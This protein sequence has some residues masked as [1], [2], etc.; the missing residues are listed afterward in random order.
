MKKIFLIIVWLIVSAQ[1]TAQ[2]QN[3]IIDN[4]FPTIVNEQ[5]LGRA[6]MGGDTIFISSARTNPLKFQYTNGNADHPLVVIN[7]GGQVKIDRSST[8]SWGAIT[9]ENCKYIKISGSGHPNYKYGFQLAADVCGLAFSDLSS[10]C[11]AEFI[12][13]SHD[14]FYGIMAKK[15]YD[16]NP[17][18][19]YPL[20]ENLLIHDC[21]IE[22]VSEGM[23]LGE[24][25]SPGM[26]FKHVKIY[27]NIVR[28]TLR[29]TIQIANMVEDVEIY[30][31]TLLNAGLEN[32]AFQSNI[33]QIGDNSVANVYNNILI[34]A[35]ST[36]II[37]F[38]KGDCHFTNNYLADNMGMFLDNRIFMDSLAPISIKQNY[39]SAIKGN[40]IIKNYNEINYF[41]VEDN[42]YDT[43]ITFFLNQSG[44]QTNFTQAT[45]NLTSIPAIEF[46]N[47]EAN[48]YSLTSNNPIAYKNMG[49]PGGPEYFDP[50]P[51]QIIIT[52]EMIIDLTFGGSVNSPLFL[53]DEQNLD[54]KSNVHP[55]SKSW[56]PDYAMNNPSYHVIIDLG[57]EYHISEINLHDM[58]AVSDFTVEYEKNLEWTTLFVDPCNTYKQW[59]DN[60]TNVSTRYL[61]LSMYDNVFAA[62]N[63]IMIYGYPAVVTKESEQIVITSNMITDK[64][65]GGSVNSP[66]LMFDEQT[67]N[68]KNGE[69]AI[70]NSWKPYYTNAN[71]PYY[72][73]ID[74]G[75]E[76]HISE[77]N[78]HDMNATFNFTV[79]YGDPTKWNPLFVDSL[80]SFKFWNKHSLDISTRYLRLSMQDNPNAYVNEIIIY[81]YPV[82]NPL[83]IGKDENFDDSHI[84]I[85]PDMVTDLVQ[86][87]SIHSPLFLFDEQNLEIR[88]GL[89]PTSNSWKPDYIMHKPSYHALVDLGQE[90]DI[91]KINLHDMND[92]SDFTVEYGDGTNW[93]TLFI[94]P[95]DTYIKWSENKTAITTRYLRFS[96]YKN[97]TAY[98]NEVYIYGY[99]TSTS[100]STK[101]VSAKTTTNTL[102][103]INAENIEI[104]PNPVNQTLHIK[105]PMNN[106]GHNNVV[107]TDILGK[108]IFSEDYL[109]T[110][111]T[112]FINLTNLQLPKASGVY[113][114]TIY[115]ESGEF[116]T[117]KF[118]KK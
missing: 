98:V 68:L 109:I 49:A 118:V 93:T 47:P 103:N 106:I 100:T 88:S 30:N 112:P 113:S 1:I 70:S 90:Y 74:L 45:N 14:G 87:G 46:E 10:D 19:P 73:E 110:E 91:S 104:Y 94:D 89:H 24:T 15:N 9:F 54:Y 37:V 25:K 42:H 33:L 64:V 13:I 20:F 39:F 114:I 95:C 35:P 50:I 44:N 67:I 53:F 99:P 36:G 27:N 51:E 82:I 60:K 86:G 78:L 7:K 5:S 96:M 115:H 6:T 62:V 38:G 34:N 101:S 66:L 63:E 58:N 79:E 105:F 59:S 117:L 108:T 21:F 56:K 81:G 116:N 3:F 72:V 65:S 84:I 75:K 76:Y 107:I 29:E 69:H 41:T 61:R 43:D 22:N 8:Y 16:G 12:K 77:I 80:S 57:K 18:L 71:A 48:D 17:P 85:T 55:T 4:S 40:Q 23:Y 31:N 26:E 52:P 32:L 111:E 28:N 102:I 97:V 2:N 83:E 11:E 92:K